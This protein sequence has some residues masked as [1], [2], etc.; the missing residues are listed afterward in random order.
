M[1]ALKRSHSGG[2]PFIKDS[3]CGRVLL[4][5]SQGAGGGEA[6]RVRRLAAAEHLQPTAGRS[7]PNI[8]SPTCPKH[9]LRNKL[10]S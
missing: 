4:Q 8:G 10:T 3:I 9:W 2:A 7:Q 6:L 5:R 1:K